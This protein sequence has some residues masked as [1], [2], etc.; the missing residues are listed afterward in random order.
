MPT[1]ESFATEPVPA[2]V[3]IALPAVAVAPAVAVVAVPL[4]AGSVGVADTEGV[5]DDDVSGS[6]PGFGASGTTTA[7]ASVNG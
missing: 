1:F 4:P 5:T 6:A 7:F 3:G 2:G